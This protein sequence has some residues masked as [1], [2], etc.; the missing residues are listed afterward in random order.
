VRPEDAF[1]LLAKEVRWAERRGVQR[2]RDPALY[3]YDVFSFGER[4]TR[5]SADLIREIRSGLV[6]R[7]EPCL[8]ECDCI[9][10][11][12]SVGNRWALL[13]ADAVSRPLVVIQLRGSEE[14]RYPGL[15][16]QRAVFVD[17]VVSGGS[18]AASLVDEV[19]RSG[20]RIIAI[21]AI[22]VKGRDQPA[23]SMHRNIP[24]RCL[25]RLDGDEL[26]ANE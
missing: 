17:D 12:A 26:L 8:S 2:G 15:D 5:M 14:D 1:P 20:G 3:K 7:L 23:L 22:V 9:V 11:P 18:T 13:V 25:L 24:I 21:L 4:G 10:A 6:D 19:N 16:G